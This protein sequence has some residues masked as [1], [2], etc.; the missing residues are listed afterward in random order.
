MLNYI[1][2]E[3]TSGLI[4]KICEKQ[5][6]LILYKTSEIT[7]ISTYLKETKVNFNL[8]K[9]FIIE[10]DCLDNLEKEIIDSIYSFSRL[11]PKIRIIVLAQGIPNQSNLLN[12]LY[13][14]GIYNIINSTDKLEIEK[15]LI[16]CL[17]KEGISKEEAK[18]F[19]KIEVVQEKNNKFTKVKIKI[20][21]MINQLNKKIQIKNINLNEKIESR[22]HYSNN[23]VFFLIYEVLRAIYNVLVFIWTSFGILFLLNSQFRHIIFQ[24]LG[25]K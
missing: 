6:I 20:Q 5:N 16:K 22:I 11:H 7:N 4:Q 12:S 14:H 24:I 1:A 23:S 25:L 10:I 3:A 2:T 15:Q 17:S 8:I 18:I 13:S 21:N 19:E 9:Y